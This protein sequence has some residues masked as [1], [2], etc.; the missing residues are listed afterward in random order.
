MA[1]SGLTAADGGNRPKSLAR[2]RRRYRPSLFADT[3]ASHFHQF[4]DQRVR[5][6]TWS[7]MLTTVRKH[8]LLFSQS[9]YAGGQCGS[10]ALDARLCTLPT[11]ASDAEQQKQARTTTYLCR[12]DSIQCCG[13]PTKLCRLSVWCTTRG[14]SFASRAAVG[15]AH[16]ASRARKASHLG[17]GALA[18]PIC[19][20][21]AEH[22]AL[23]CSDKIGCLPIHRFQPA[24]PSLQ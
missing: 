17:S 21:C 12:R 14:A 4:F 13:R 18:S 20:L 24:V 19:S 22:S 1:H 5:M 6:M 3:R 15:A 2:G 9:S 16:E 7:V 8:S 11:R 23:E 10:R